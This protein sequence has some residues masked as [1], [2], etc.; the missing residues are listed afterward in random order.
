M[1]IGN[2]ELKNKLQ[3]SDIVGPK[4]ILKKQQY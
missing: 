3:V 1:L 2:L 4:L